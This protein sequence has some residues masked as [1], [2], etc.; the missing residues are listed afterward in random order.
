MTPPTRHLVVGQRDPDVPRRRRILCKQV[1]V[2]GFD[3]RERFEPGK[4]A[5]CGLAKMS[6]NGVAVKPGHYPEGLP[7]A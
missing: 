2:R 3:L 1:A 7:A 4:P 5:C 6:L